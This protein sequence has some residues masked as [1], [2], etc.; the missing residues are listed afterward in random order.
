MV[1]SKS[2]PWILDKDYDAR[3]HSL[4]YNH[5]FLDY[6][7]VHHVILRLPCE[8]KICSSL[9]ITDVVDVH[10]MILT[11]RNLEYASITTSKYTPWGNGP[12]KSLCS[13][14]HGFRRSEDISSGSG[15]F[16]GPYA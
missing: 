15:Q 13:V 2:I 3:C 11:S 12:Q 8:A 1:I 10:W 16:S 7:V 4:S 5:I 6:Q 14:C 9:D